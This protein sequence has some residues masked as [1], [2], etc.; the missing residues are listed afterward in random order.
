MKQSLQSWLSWTWSGSFQA[1]S[2]WGA[3]AAASAETGG[4][5]KGF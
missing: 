3:H 1:I 5:A 2:G 4:E